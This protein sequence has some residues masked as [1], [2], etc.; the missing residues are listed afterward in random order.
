M[1]YVPIRGEIDPIHGASWAVQAGWTLAIGRALTRE[2]VLQPVQVSPAIVEGG[3]WNLDGAAPDAWGTPIPVDHAPLSVGRLGAVLVPGLAFDHHGHRLGRGA[4]VY[5]R[6][7]AT[8]P[9][10]TL[11]I[12]AITDA[13]LVDRLPTEAHDVPM[14][15]VVTPTRVIRCERAE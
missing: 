12:G 6:F 2:A 1:V 11:R 8:L 14:H 13:R 4:G 7:L 5:D 3:R 9:P 10:T 15:A